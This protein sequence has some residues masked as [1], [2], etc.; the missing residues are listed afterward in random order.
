MTKFVHPLFL[1]LCMAMLVGFTS[2][3]VTAEIKVLS[4]GPLE[5]ALTKI[6]E[7]FRRES[8]HTLTFEYGLSPVIHKKVLDGEV[9]DIVLIQPNFI[10]ELV[11]AGKLAASTTPSHWSRRRW[12]IYPSRRHCPQHLNT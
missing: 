7:T 11:K 5:P 9:A 8:N 1:M 3:A 12:F 6:A 4:D 2:S 10:D